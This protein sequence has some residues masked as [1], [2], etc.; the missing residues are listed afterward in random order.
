MI[1]N[2]KRARR[3]SWQYER[4]YPFLRQITIGQARMRGF[5]TM[6]DNV[7]ESRRDTGDLPDFSVL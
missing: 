1:V 7:D 2:M 3:R 4:H 6:T 5:P